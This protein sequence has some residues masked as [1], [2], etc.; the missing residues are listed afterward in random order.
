MDKQMADLCIRYMNKFADFHG[1]RHAK[2]VTEHILELLQAESDGRLVV[3]TIEDIHP[4]RS[5]DVGW[6]GISS[7]GCDSCE[8]HCARLKEYNEKYNT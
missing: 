1:Y 5:C 2:K 3:L 4:C 8:N 6:G 7:E